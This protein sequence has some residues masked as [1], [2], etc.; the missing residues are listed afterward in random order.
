MI[1]IILLIS[2]TVTSYL[3][4]YKHFATFFLEGKP[5]K[6]KWFEL[7]IYLTIA[8]VF[9]WIDIILII[10]YLIGFLK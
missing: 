8:A 2:N 7:L 6:G 10:R 5:S 9:S 3:L 1:A 4:A